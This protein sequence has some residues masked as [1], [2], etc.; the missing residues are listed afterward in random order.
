MNG[1]H[2]VRNALYSTPKNLMMLGK[3]QISK[4]FIVGKNTEFY[5]T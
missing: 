1:I 5:D 3:N 4:L 2:S